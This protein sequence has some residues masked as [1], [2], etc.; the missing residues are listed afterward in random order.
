MGMNKNT[1]DYIFGDEAK[2]NW[3]KKNRNGRLKKLSFSNLPILNIFSKNFTDWSLEL[4]VY[5]GYVIFFCFISPNWVEILMTTLVSSPKQ[6]L[7]KEMQN[8]VRKCFFDVVQ[9]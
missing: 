7:R 4:G 6:H 2:K 8:S 9:L 1:A 3:E 5:V